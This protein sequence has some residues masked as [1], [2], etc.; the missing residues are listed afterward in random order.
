VGLVSGKDGLDIPL[1]I[2]AGAR[3]HL[4]RQGVLV[5]EVGESQER[6]QEALPEISFLWLDF[7]SGGSGVF[8]L[9]HEQ[10]ERAGGAALK[11]LRERAGV[12]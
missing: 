11:L 12:T 3:D 5:C 10:L 7:E 4:N 1:R 6:L 9:E 2:I 8:L